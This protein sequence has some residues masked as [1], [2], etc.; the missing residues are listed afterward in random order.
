MAIIEHYV[1]TEK[2]VV[3][4]CWCGIL[5]AIPESLDKQ[6]RGES[7]HTVYC[8]LGHDWVVRETA[9]QK[10]QKELQ[11]ERQQHD[12]T[13]AALADEKVEVRRQRHLVNAE[14]S[15]KT[16]IKNRVA[17]GVCPCCTRSFSNLRR[18]MESKHPNYTKE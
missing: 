18:H 14:R 10:L 4:R 15:A 2:L 11:R 6:A 17:N 12:Q 1:G 3:E 7:R 16:R 9:A 8:P 5:H 13:R